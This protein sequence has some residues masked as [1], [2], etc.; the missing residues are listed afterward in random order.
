MKEYLI[1]RIHG[2]MA[3]WGQAAVGG[4]RPTGMQPTRSAMIGLLAAA[5]GIKRD[6]EDA[7]QALQLSIEIAVK[8]LVPS[9]L[10]RDY[11]TSQVPP[12]AKNVIHRSRKSEL[13]EQKQ[14]L[15]TILSSRDYRC[16]GLWVVGV[17]LR[18]GS[19]L[20]LINIRDALLRPKFTLYLGRKSCVLALPLQPTIRQRESIKSALD[21]EF[22]S[23]TRSDKEDAMW[24]GANGSVTYFWEG[25]VTE[26]DSEAVMTTQPWDEPVNRSRWQFRQRFQHQLTVTEG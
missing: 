4:D 11:H 8:A 14:K 6:D 19:N 3:S 12:Q 13:S 22:P 2:P 24:L 10:M 1:F 23:I 25:A 16:D 18:K 21:H 9:S 15:K 17:S 26:F 5:M 20:S 7:L